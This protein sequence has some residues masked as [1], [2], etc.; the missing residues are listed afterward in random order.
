MQFTYL[1][2]LFFCIIGMVVL[3]RQYSLALF[4]DVR[5]TVLTLIVA[6]AVF[7]VWDAL[8]IGLGIF[9]S[10]QSEYMTG[11]YLAP[12]VPVEELFFL[13]FL[14]YFTLIVYLLGEKLWPRT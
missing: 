6:V 8:G 1:G 14:S 11:W 7:V 10:G 13:A 9:F 5:A 12:E 4:R 2:I 3:D